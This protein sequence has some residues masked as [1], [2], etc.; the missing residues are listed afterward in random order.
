MSFT[1]LG[2]GAYLPAGSFSNEDMA[3]I[4]DTNHEWIHSR[5]GIAN[6]RYVTDENTHDLALQ[7]AKKAL[8]DAKIDPLDVDAILVAT[9]TPSALIPSV[10][11]L[12]AD[13]LGCRED[14][15]AFDMNGACSGFIYGLETAHALLSSDKYKHIMVIGAEVISKVMDFNDRRT[16]I[17]FGDG[18]GA[19][20]VTNEGKGSYLWSK[21]YRKTDVKHSLYA[22]GIAINNPLVKNEQLPLVIGMDGTVVFQFAIEAIHQAIRDFT[23]ATGMTLDELDHVVLHQANQRITAHIAK[24]YKQKT[25][26][27][28][29]VIEDYGNTSAASI[30]IALDTLKT[31]DKL[32]SGDKILMIG[33]GG[34]LTY[35]AFALTV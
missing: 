22:P 3:K 32:K 30:P 15:L 2:V 5:S 6:R 14:I 4:V 7:A 28:V 13:A 24:T 9:F 27:F 33:F 34:G 35:G 10:A 21:A 18:A 1:L 26:K 25:D 29:S 20:L 16:C 12:V 8:A 31:Q 23:Q 19:A 17:L 11:C